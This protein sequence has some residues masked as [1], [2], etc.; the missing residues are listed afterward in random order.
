MSQKLLVFLLATSA[1]SIGIFKFIPSKSISWTAMASPPE[2]LEPAR[3]LATLNKVR[4]LAL[5]SNSLLEQDP[6]IQAWAEQLITSRS[7]TSPHFSA[8]Q[9]LNNLQSQV[10]GVAAASAGVFRVPYQIE[11]FRTEFAAWAEVKNPTYTHFS[12][13][14]RPHSD[15]NLVDAWAILVQRL[16]KFDP[17]LLATGLQQFHHVCALCKRPYNGQFYAGDR[18]LLL[19]C[20][21]CETNY[22]ILAVNT[23]DQYARANTFFSRISP[24]AAFRPNVSPYEEMISLWHGVLDHCSYEND[25]DVNTATRAK[26]SWQTSAETLQ[27]RSGDCEDTSILLADWLMSRGIEA[28]V[29]IGETDEREGHAWCIA[30]I[31]GNVF[32]LET[33][34]EKEDLPRDPPLA[35]Q[36]TD[37]Y[38][39]EYLFDR[40][41]LYFFNSEPGQGAGDCWNKF[42]WKAVDY[43]SSLPPTIEPSLVEAPWFPSSKAFFAANVVPAVSGE[44]EEVAGSVTEAAA[45]LSD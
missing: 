17:K 23:V 2:K 14:L 41:Q 39:A 16:P 13:V 29:V 5:Q 22:D 38:R 36:S 18:V 33:T 21:Q 10:K 25:Y 30:R 9:I 42:A 44:A 31:D 43:S 26:D 4:S 8:E 11:A 20:P 40:T 7:P 35:K 24:L 19:Q 28:R 6:N 34:G 15:R 12:I 1:I 32:L 37:K 3:L 45:T 27:R